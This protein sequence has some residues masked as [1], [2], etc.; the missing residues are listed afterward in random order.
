[1]K[2]ELFS[3][4]LCAVFSLLRA[5]PNAWI[6]EI[7]YDNEGLDQNEF[8]EVIVADPE[9]LSLPDLTLYMYNGRNGEPYCLDCISE[10]IPGERV[11]PFQYYT[12]YQRGIQKR[13]R[14]DDPCLSRH[15]GGYHR[16]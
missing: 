11:G 12:W 2:R 5:V 1:M 4:V 3:L 9:A 15:P 16:V 7:H 6:N 8:V 13:H 14:R 10:F